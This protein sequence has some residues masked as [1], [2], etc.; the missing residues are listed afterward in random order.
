MNARPLPD[1]RAYVAA[2]RLV[3]T[4]HMDGSPEK[5]DD[6]Y[7]VLSFIED[8]QELEEPPPSSILVVGCRLGYE[9]R[10]L[11]KQWPHAEV[12]GLDIVPQFIEQASKEGKAILADMHALPFSPHAFQWIFCSGTLEHAYD[13]PLVAREMLRV[14]SRGI[15]VTAD[16]EPFPSTNA[17][18]WTCTEDPKEWE[19][20]FSHPE[21]RILSS[22]LL[23][24]SLHLI[25]MRG[26]L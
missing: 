22:D 14:A 7:T 16:I 3:N 23:D 20:L 9:M 5:L 26:A 17:S 10:H 1:P 13:A 4:I 15:Y 19:A 11:R 12:V 25:L 2:Q 8:L 6:S 24:R 18:H 21:W